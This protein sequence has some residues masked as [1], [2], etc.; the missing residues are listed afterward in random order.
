MFLKCVSWCIYMLALKKLFTLF[1][2]LLLLW[3]SSCSARMDGVVREGGAAVITIKTSLEP[4]TAMLIGSL[5]NFMG[6]KADGPILDGPAIGRSMEAVPGIGAVAF[7]NTGPSA[8]DGSISVP[9]LANFFVSGGE[10]S[11]FISYTEGR[12]KGSSSIIINL[13]RESAPDIISKLSPEIEGYLSA[14]MAPVVLGETSTKQEYL[15]MV[16]MIYGR[17][18]SD[19]ISAARIRAF[20]EFPRPV[21]SALGGRVSGKQVEFEIPLADLLVLERPLRYEVNW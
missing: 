8:L 21:S 10:R 16:A 6:E 2:A 15:D 12:N 13:D 3:V 4:R 17:S 18:L 19:E 5:R 7:S 11:R 9:N 1:P 20:I 14:L